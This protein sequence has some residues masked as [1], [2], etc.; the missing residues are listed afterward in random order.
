MLLQVRGEVR[1]A[2]LF[3]GVSQPNGS[4]LAEP[5][6]DVAVELKGVD[7]SIGDSSLLK[8]PNKHQTLTSDLAKL[9][10]SSL[11][12]GFSGA[13]DFRT[14]GVNLEALFP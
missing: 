11:I 7:I 12:D 3:I 2:S 4:R 8:H 9:L 13:R 5:I 6:Y 10:R 1:V 14:I